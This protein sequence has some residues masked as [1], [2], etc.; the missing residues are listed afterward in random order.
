M[1]SKSHIVTKFKDRDPNY[2]NKNGKQL[3]QY[4][5]SREEALPMQTPILGIIKR[6]HNTATK[7]R[8]N[9]RNFHPIP[10]CFQNK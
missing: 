6:A 5:K 2:Y 7:R 8:T 3:Q 4:Q 1:L 9:T 10:G